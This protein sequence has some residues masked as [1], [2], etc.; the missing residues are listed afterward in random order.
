MS[1]TAGEMKAAAA[2]V[3]AAVSPVRW[4]VVFWLSQGSV[5]PCLFP[6]DPPSFLQEGKGHIPFPSFF[7]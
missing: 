7:L 5:A 2:N 3:A 4:Q 1:V 6:K